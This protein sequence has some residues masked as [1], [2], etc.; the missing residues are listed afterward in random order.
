LAREKEVG[1]RLEA[2]ARRERERR[3]REVEAMVARV[4]RRRE[5]HLAGRLA[6]LEHSQYREP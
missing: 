2:E 4:A 5:D 6:G 1:R 3:E